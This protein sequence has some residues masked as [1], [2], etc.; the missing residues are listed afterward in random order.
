MTIPWPNQSAAAN[1]RPALQP[2][3][4]GNLAATVAA[5]RAF[6]GL[7]G[8]WERT[9]RARWTPANRV[10]RQNKPYPTAPQSFGELLRK[11]RLDVGLTQAQVA[12]K[13]GVSKS[14][15]DKWE[16][17]WTKPPS[18][19]HLA[20]TGFLPFDP[21]HKSTDPTAQKVVGNL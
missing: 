1:R 8:I 21:L 4:A 20:I 19:Y 2:D 3:G 16:C 5:D 11:H 10:W 13:L 6:L 12:E 17:N 15:I 18:R 9:I 14:T 7:L